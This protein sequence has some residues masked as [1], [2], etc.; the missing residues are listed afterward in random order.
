MEQYAS[1]TKPRMTA[2]EV[3]ALTDRI[4]DACFAVHRNMGPGLSETIYEECLIKEFKRRKINYG[5]QVRIEIKYLGEPLS[6]HL[7]L[8]LLVED[9]VILELKAVE[10]FAPIHEAQLLTYMRL[11]Q[12]QIGYLINFNVKL[13]KYGIRRLRIG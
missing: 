10:D 7:I 8:D 9:E 6:K 5:S 1:V 12:K 11:T 3:N 2:T 4:V 13:M